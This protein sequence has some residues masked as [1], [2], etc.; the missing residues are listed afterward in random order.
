MFWVIC[1]DI[2][3][4]KR[5]QRL[6]KRLEQRCQRVQHSVF[7]VSMPEA[8]L[9]R[10]LETQWL[11]ALNLQEDSLRI[12]PLDAGTQQRAKV[13]GGQPLY[14]PPDVLIL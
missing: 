10:L 1:Y 11:P 9:V 4:N 14:E 5:R 12:Y 3:D 6:A 2:H 13:Y 7:E 8:V